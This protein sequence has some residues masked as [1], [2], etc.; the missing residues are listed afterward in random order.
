MAITKSGEGKSGVISQQQQQHNNNN[1]VKM[2][3]AQ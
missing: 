1:N 2:G 3:L